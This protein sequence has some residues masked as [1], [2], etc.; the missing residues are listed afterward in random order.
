MLPGNLCTVMDV[1]RWLPRCQGGDSFWMPPQASSAAPLVDNLFYLLL[2]I[3]T[4]FFVLIVVLMG[5]FVVVYRRGRAVPAGAATH[6]N[7]LELVWTGI[8]VAIVVLV[9]YEGF[10]GFMELRTVPQGA[11]EVRVTAQKWEWLFQYP[12][13]TVDSKLHVPVDEPVQLV[14]TSNDVI[15]SLFIPAFR[16]KMDVVPGRYARTWFRATTPGE[17]D[18]YCSEYCGT[19]HSGMLSTVVVHPPGG[20]EQ[21]LRETASAAASKSPVEYGEMLYRQRGCAG[22]HTLDGSAGTGPSFKGIYGHPVELQQGPPV[23]VEDNYIRESILE[24]QA[25]IVKGY[26]GVMPTYKGLLSDK[27]ITALIEFIKSRK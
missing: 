5:V 27:D 10:S 7:M 1:L 24:P 9:F 23:E 6:N 14:M 4:F 2:A 13:G 8:P 22:C 19:G 21:W 18:L 25:K 3:S 17:Y 11:R 16:V 15:H 12:D 26:Q 20:F